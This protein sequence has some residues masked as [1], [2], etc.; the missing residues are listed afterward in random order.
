MISG[1]FKSKC[2]NL[3]H[4]ALTRIWIKHLWWSCCL[5]LNG[6]FTKTFHLITHMLLQA[7]FSQWPTKGDV[8]QIVIGWQPESPF[9]LIASFFPR[10]AS[11]WW[12]SRSFCLTSS[13]KQ[14]T[15]VW[16]NMRVSK[17]QWHFHFHLN[18]PFNNQMTWS[19]KVFHKTMVWVIDTSVAIVSGWGCFALRWQHLF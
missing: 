5:N 1:H 18:C 14:D 13:W 4:A 10:K 7:D 9:T 12:P 2:V 6:Q 19:C 3:E 8:R 16:N 11:E 17:W 15:G